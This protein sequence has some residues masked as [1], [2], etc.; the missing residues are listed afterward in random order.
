MPVAHVSFDHGSGTCLWLEDTMDGW[1]DPEQLPISAALRAELIRVAEWY[2]TALNRDYPPD[3]GPW[4]EDECQRFNAAVRDLVVRLRTELSPD[5]VLRDCAEEM[6]EDP[7]LDRYLAD[8]VGF[9][10]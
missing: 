4:R 2:D 6:H 3:P 10:R 8:P 7:D 9:R 1:V 5:W